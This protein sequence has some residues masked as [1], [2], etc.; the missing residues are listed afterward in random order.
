MCEIERALLLSSVVCVLYISLNL[1]CMC[2][3]YVFVNNWYYHD[4]C[5]AFVL[6]LVLCGAVTVPMCG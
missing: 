2:V 6:P 4:H 3:M 5:Q 1:F